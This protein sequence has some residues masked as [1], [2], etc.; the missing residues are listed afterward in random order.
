MILIE[1]SKEPKSWLSHRLTQGA[2]YGATDDLRNALLKD[3]GYICA[4]CMRRIPVEDNGASETSRIEHVTPQSSLTQKEAMDFGNMVI[5]CP[6]A[7]SSTANNMTHCD[8]HK[9][10]S[11]IS[12]SPFDQNFIDSISYAT[13]GSIKSSVKQ[14][15]AEINQVLNLNIPLLKLNRRN[16]RYSIVAQLSKRSWTKPELEKILKAYTSKDEKG[17]RMEY[18]GVVIS[19]L[20]KKLKIIN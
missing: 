1:K 11:P 10:Q 18:C 8:R 17:M 19:Y 16:V 20:T 4:Y 7:I 6:G 9:A 2:V 13:D 14:Y 12:F 15:D 5:C 3:Q